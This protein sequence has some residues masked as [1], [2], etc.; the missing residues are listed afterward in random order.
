LQHQ[1]S[2]AWGWAC[3]TVPEK[4]TCNHAQVFGAAGSACAQQEKVTCWVSRPWEKQIF[5][6]YMLIMTGISMVLTI[7]EAIY[8]A[9]HVTKKG[10]QRRAGERKPSY[11]FTQPNPQ[12]QGA[13]FY[14][15]SNFQDNMMTMKSS[16]SVK[17]GLAAA[18]AWRYAAQRGQPRSNSMVPSYNQ[19]M[20]DPRQ[21]QYAGAPLI[22]DF[23]PDDAGPPRSS[24]RQFRR[25][26][27]SPGSANPA[28][29]NSNVNSAIP[30]NSAKEASTEELIN[31]KNQSDS[32]SGSNKENATPGTVRQQ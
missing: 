22:D 8:M 12:G 7:L 10:L 15:A 3:W 25:G 32:S 27:F 19:F 21:F 29:Q 4:Y 17:R 13:M 23:L 16:A 28:M 18:N 11:P 30:E 26:T 14:D 2:R 5:L 20:N 31:L 1:Q 6:Y 24:N 9:F